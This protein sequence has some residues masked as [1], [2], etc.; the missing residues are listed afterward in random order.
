MHSPRLP[1]LQGC[2]E[3]LSQV[4]TSRARCAHAVPA[5]TQRLADCACNRL[6]LFS[7]RVVLL[8]R[9]LAA[10]H[11][12]RSCWAVGI[13]LSVVVVV[14]TEGTRSIHSFYVWYKTQ[15]NSDWQ[16]AAMNGTFSN[17]L[18]SNSCQLAPEEA[19]SLIVAVCLPGL[20]MCFPS[21]SSASVSLRCGADVAAVVTSLPLLPES[22]SDC[23]TAGGSSLRTAASS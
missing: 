7:Q 3:V 2:P 16:R 14:V 15:H 1:G 19:V 5:G 17:A 8:I 13:L 6:N 22:R 23:S 11:K 20:L 12:A 21:T 18:R 4:L 9:L 10:R